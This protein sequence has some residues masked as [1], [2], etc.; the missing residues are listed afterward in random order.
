MIGPSAPNG[1]PDPIEIFGPLADTTIGKLTI[2][3][4]SDGSGLTDFKLQSGVLTAVAGVTG[5]AVATWR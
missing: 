4:E 1:P 5:M 3:T 2:G